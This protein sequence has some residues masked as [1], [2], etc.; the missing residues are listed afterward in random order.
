MFEYRI[1]DY[2]RLF[3]VSS[4]AVGFYVSDIFRNYYKKFDVLITFSDGIWT[5]YIPI[6]VRDELLKKGVKF[7]SDKA[8]FL[9]YSQEFDLFIK[10][11]S[12]FFVSLLEKQEITSEDVKKAFEFTT[13]HFALYHKTEFFYTDQAFLEFKRSGDE[14]LHSNLQ[15]LEVIKTKGREHLNRLF[16]G[17]DGYSSQLARKI[18]SQF[19][20]PDSDIMAYSSREILQ[21]FNGVRVV[22][23]ELDERKESFVTIDNDKVLVYIGKEAKNF[24]NQLD[25]TEEIKQL[26]GQ[27]ANSGI[28]K[29][30]VKVIPSDYYYDFG[31]L[32]EIFADLPNKFI[33]VAETTSPELIPACKKA[34][35]I[36][37]NQG[38]LLSHA[39]IVSREMNIPCLVGVNDATSVLKD[40]ME[41]EVDAEKGVV[42]IIK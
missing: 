10:G 17:Y 15:V 42:R 19:D 7:Y 31:K 27:I 5:C 12:E 28:V 1:E 34:I 39:A 16:F 9:Q 33:L 29:G 24:I 4:D 38:G 21:L 26:S 36:V 35:A 32:K 3:Q 25:V 40:G 41:V 2:Q 30:S 37:T 11:S 22:R 20:V 23:K 13:K 18:A 8:R 14:S 6:A